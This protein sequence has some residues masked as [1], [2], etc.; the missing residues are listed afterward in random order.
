MMLSVFIAKRSRTGFNFSL[1]IDDYAVG[2]AQ[3]YVRISRRRIWKAISLKL[4][5]E[6]ECWRKIRCQKSNRIIMIEDCCEYNAV[7]RQSSKL[8]GLFVVHVFSV[9]SGSLGEWTIIGLLLGQYNSHSLL[10]VDCAM[11]VVGIRNISRLDIVVVA[12][13]TEIR[14]ERHA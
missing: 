7:R 9:E 10:I 11:N 6:N 1:H 4:F 14:Y 5:R 3:D 2:L 12:W 8:A 13:S